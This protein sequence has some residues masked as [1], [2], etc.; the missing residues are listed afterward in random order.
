MPFSINCTNKGCS[1]FQ[2]PYIDPKT[3][4]VYC[5]LCEGEIAN[6]THFTK[7]QL[8]TLKQYKPK[9]FTSFSVKCQHCSKEARPK[10][11][12]QDIVCPGCNK[13]HEHLSEPF[14]IMLREK[15]KSAG[16]DI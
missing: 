14:K 7:V 3:D 10:L 1:K 5:S 8:K 6:I 15:L 4:K 16:N 2:E 12:G 11:Q 9:T 13:R